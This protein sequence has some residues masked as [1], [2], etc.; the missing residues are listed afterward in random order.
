[1]SRLGL[2]RR[3]QL[4]QLGAHRLL[5]PVQLLHDVLID[6]GAEQL[7]EDALAVL[8]LGA[9]QRHE[10]ALGDHGHLHEL[11]LAQADDFHQLLVGLLLVLG[12][13]PPVRQDE[14]HGL[15]LV[16]E[17]GAPAHGPPVPGGAPHSVHLVGL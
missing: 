2:Q 14:G 9:Q 13:L 7:A 11:L 3:A 15:P 12:I 17:A 4:G 6:G 1:M 5:P 16:G 8:G 10:L